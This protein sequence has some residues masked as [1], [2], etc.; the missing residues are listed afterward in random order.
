VLS[1][2]KPSEDEKGII[3][4]VYNPMRETISG[5]VA[6]LFRVSKVMR[7]NLREEDGPE[8]SSKGGYDIS[9]PPKGVLTLKALVSSAA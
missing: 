7:S 2:L 4:R 1:A 5:K 9:V 8:L 6:F 3:I